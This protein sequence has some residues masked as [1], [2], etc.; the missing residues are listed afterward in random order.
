MLPPMAAQA[1]VGG[2]WSV[3][4]GDFP[5]MAAQAFVGGY[6]GLVFPQGCFRPT[7]FGFILDFLALGCSVWVRRNDDP[8]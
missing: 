7:L 6:R 2:S 1:F 8:P 5:P 3:K 4:I